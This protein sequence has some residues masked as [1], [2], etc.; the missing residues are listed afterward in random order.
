M[1]TKARVALK[2]EVQ[3]AHRGLLK[4]GFET[5][6]RGSKR[7]IKPGF[8]SK[9]GF[10]ATRGRGAEVSKGQDFLKARVLSTRRAV[11]VRLSEAGVPLKSQCGEE[12]KPGF[13]APQK[14]PD[15]ITTQ[16]M[17]LTPPG[18]RAP[19]GTRKT[20]MFLGLPRSPK[21]PRR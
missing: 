4:P 14:G 21:K 7:Q 10:L 13:K 11:A 5:T 18:F 2:A 15:F 12:P 19:N 20:T 17:R 8:P 16:R 6:A 1:S 3:S 9:P